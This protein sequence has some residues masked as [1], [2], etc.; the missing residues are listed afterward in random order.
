MKKISLLF[1]LLS[2]ITTF[3][4][5][6]KRVQSIF[7]ELPL[8]K[9]RSEIERILQSDKRFQ[10]LDVDSEMFNMFTYWGRVLNQGIIKS[11]ADSIDIELTYGIS[12][13]SNQKGSTRLTHVKLRYFYSSL[14]TVEKEFKKLSNILNPISNNT[15]ETRIDTIYSDSPIRSQ[16]KAKGVTF[17]HNKP[18]YS[19]ELLRATILKNRFGLYIEYTRE[20]D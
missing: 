20:G 18:Y 7:Y 19:V 11:K 2:F 15:S 4:Q 3:G 5:T 12:S 13:N 8:D 10:K 1:L 16:F 6:D 14:D 17:H 9:P